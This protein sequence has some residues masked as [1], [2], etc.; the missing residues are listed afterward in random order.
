MKKVTLSLA[1]LAMAGVASAGLLVPNGDF[2]TP[3]GANWAFNDNSVNITYPTSGGNGGGFGQMEE[4]GGGWGGVLVSEINP[5]QG[6]DLAPL[7]LTAGVESTYT[8]D[9]LNVSETAF[10][11]GMKIEGWSGGALDGN[12]GDILFSVASG[13][14]TYTFDYTLSA[15]AT[16]VKFV[17]L[18][19]VQPVGSIV[20]FDNVG[21]VP[22]PATLGLLS[23]A[24][25]AMLFMRRRMRI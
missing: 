10:S 7:G 19:V 13:W 23:I 5:T 9:M 21:V 16:S 6:L 20:G 25:G 11:A 17:P 14:N 24:G 22:E 4:I 15:T 3:A 1:V 18:M 2:A 12:S 8:I